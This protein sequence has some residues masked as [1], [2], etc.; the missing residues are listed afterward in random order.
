MT[1]FLRAQI[2]LYV[3]L[4]GKSERLETFVYKCAVCGELSFSKKTDFVFCTNCGSPKTIIQ[5]ES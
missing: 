1:R 5:T 2:E 3:S 4:N